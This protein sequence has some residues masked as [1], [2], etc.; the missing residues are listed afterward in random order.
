[1]VY[2]LTGLVMYATSVIAVDSFR[3]WMKTKESTY[4]D[5]K[6]ALTLRDQGSFF[7]TERVMMN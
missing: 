7:Q 5:R 3:I 4:Y 1:V 6:K 2:W